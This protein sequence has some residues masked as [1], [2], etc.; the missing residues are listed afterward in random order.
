ME[1]EDFK[2]MI[3]RQIQDKEVK[4]TALLFL[5]Y[6]QPDKKITLT[7]KVADTI[8]DYIIGYKFSDDYQ[9]ITVWLEEPPAKSAPLAVNKE[10]RI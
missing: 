10:E 3:Q 7:K 1:Y 2:N 6:Q 9:S 4:D 5:L 8:P